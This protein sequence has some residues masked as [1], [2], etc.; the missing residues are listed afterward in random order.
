MESTLV[1][2]IM[3]YEAYQAEIKTDMQEDSLAGFLLFMNKRLGK[4]GDNGLDFGR[5]SWS[6]FNR[7]TLIEI[8]GAYVGMMGRYIDHY[9]KKSMPKTPITS[10]E[11]FTYL[12]V[13]LQ[14]KSMTKTELIHRN[15]HQITTGTEIIKRLFTKGY[16]DQ[17][18]DPNDKRSIRVSLTDA[19]KGALYASSEMTKSL[20]TLATGIL[21]D[22]ELLFL[23]SILRKL[24]DFHKKIFQESRQL[25]TQE[26]VAKYL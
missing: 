10:L 24:D 23:V 2:I 5:S 19:G 17:E 14:E 20:S 15:A 18:Q 11:E 12:I 26:L 7:Q 1:Q 13:L 25:D 8:A 21:S 22:D 3:Q 6:N 9:A 4:L 16:V